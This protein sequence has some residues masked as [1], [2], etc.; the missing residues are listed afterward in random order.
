MSKERF[1]DWLGEKRK[2]T[3]SDAFRAERSLGE[4]VYARATR[5]RLGFWEE[6]ARELHWFKKWDS[7]LEWNPPWAR[8]FDGGQLNAAYNC[9]DRHLEGPRRMKPALI[10][11]GEGGDSRTLTYE[12]LHAEVGKTAN[13]FKS[14]G[15]GKGDRVVLYMPMSVETVVCMLACARIGAVHC[16]VFGGFSAEALRE[17]I[18]DSQAKLLVTADGGRRRGRILN[19]KQI[20]DEALQGNQG[21]CACVEKVVVVE[22][23]KTPVSMGERDIFYDEGVKDMA[24]E[25]PAEVM[26]AEDMLFVLYNS[27]TTGKPKGIVHTTGG[28]MTGVATTH[29]YVFDL[30]EDDV[31]WCTADVGWIAGHS[32][33]VYGPLANGATV[34]LFEGTPDF[35]DKD[36]YWDIVEKYRVS[37]FYSSPTAIRTFMKWGVPY[38]EKHDLTSLRVLGTMG[39]P[40][41]PEVWMW[42]HK[43]VG[44]ERCPICDTWW[45]TE[46]GMMMLSPVAGL[47]DMKPGSCTLPVPGV[48][49]NVVNRAGEAVEWGYGGYL[50]VTEPWPAMMRTVYGDDNRYVKTYWSHWPGVYFT[51]DGARRDEDGYF[52]VV[53]R[54]DDVINVSGQRI[55]TMEVESALLEH[56]AV[57]EAACVGKAHDLKGQALVVFVTLRDE[58]AS[59]D[60]VIAELRQFLVGKIGAFARPEEIYVTNDLPKTRSGKIIRRLLKDIAEGRGLG[61]TAMEGSNV[62]KELYKG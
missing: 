18:M 53:G 45:Q 52:W 15:V 14:L 23:T 44:G 61:D 31:Y 37:I 62:L 19:M 5:D 60:G 30:K 59:K 4:D 55:G 56:P 32:Y 58:K 17:R 26:E 9:L 40:I 8:W 41:N 50:T 29:K 39:E 13:F 12:Q 22:R 51:G 16:V 1:E 6:R 11:E 34:L 48:K 54:V 49:M 38:L 28:Y 47:V 42:Y 25:C 2:V 36:R 10:F 57:A 20:A 7:V 33:C 24:V 21:G 46:T 43:Y 3:V 35:P 27:G